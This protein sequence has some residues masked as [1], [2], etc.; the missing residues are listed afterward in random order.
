MT[1]SS[2]SQV[3]PIFVVNCWVLGNPSNR[4]F[5]VKVA[6]DE[7]AGS[8]RKAIK[9]EIKPE[10]DHVAANSIVLWNVSNKSIAVDEAI[11]RNVD[12]LNLNNA[13]PISPV[14]IL[15]TEFSSGLVRHL[16]HVVIKPPPLGKYQNCMIVQPC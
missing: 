15:A 4:V 3:H 16:L 5:S 13:N 7:L 11:E 9:E 8:F 14:E 2:I 6:A 10:F 1:S 12:N